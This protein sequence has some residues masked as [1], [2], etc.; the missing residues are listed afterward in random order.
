MGIPSTLVFRATVR[1]LGLDA[2]CASMRAWKLG[3]NFVASVQFGVCR[4]RKL[5]LSVIPFSG[6]GEGWLVCHI[7][8]ACINEMI[9]SC[10]CP[11]K[12]TSKLAKN[13]RECSGRRR[14]ANLESERVIA[15]KS[16]QHESIASTTNPT[17]CYFCCYRAMLDQL[18]LALIVISPQGVVT[19]M[20][21]TMT[22]IIG[23]DSN[24]SSCACE[25]TALHPEGK[26][27][28]LL[29]M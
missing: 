18:G 16:F 14:V 26:T 29:Q 28:W 27:R 4:T 21:N 2:G 5:T 6:T 13:M 15:S 25:H 10:R 1:I 7:V 19:R 24:K 23:Q 12:R 8:Y 20:N 11:V 3:H 17:L 22:T 9:C